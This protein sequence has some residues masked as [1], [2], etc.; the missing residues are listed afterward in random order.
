VSIET[1]ARPRRTRAQSREDNR[2]ALL[3]AAQELIVEVGYSGAQLDEI[4]DRAGLTKGAIYSI[5]GGKL[6]LLR[7]VVEEHASE[8]M[9]QLEWDF[10]APGLETAEDLIDSLVRGYLRLLERSDTKQL[11]AFELDLGGL[12]LRDTATLA[13]VLMREKALAN[14]LADALAGRARRTGSPLSP[15]QAA[16]AADLV[17]GCLGG[18]GQ[19]LVTAHW[20]SRDPNAISAAV[21]RLLPGAAS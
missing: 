12:A 11:L 4:A 18:L 16:I 13:A 8:V 15:E 7:A 2:R 3:A 14:R 19:R 9:P 10:D 5:F 20:M 6:E 1:V 21:V 17:L